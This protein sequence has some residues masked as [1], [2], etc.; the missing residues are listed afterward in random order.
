[1]RRDEVQVTISGT[2]NA[3]SRKRSSIGSTN[4]SEA[5]KRKEVDIHIADFAFNSVDLRKSR[6]S[7]DAHIRDKQV[8]TSKSG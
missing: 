5:T 8:V 2:T 1:M 3:N 7:S 4:G 6:H